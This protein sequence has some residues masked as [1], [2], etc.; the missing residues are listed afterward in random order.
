MNDILNE[1]FEAWFKSPSFGYFNSTSQ[2]YTLFSNLST[3][4]F[5]YI[6]S[7]SPLVSPHSFTRTNRVNIVIHYVSDISRMPN[8]LLR[9]KHS[10]FS[11]ISPEIRIHSIAH[12]ENFL[13]NNRIHRGM[14]SISYAASND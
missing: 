3:R 5:R 1:H 8:S 6:I 7:R 2:R 9:N 12:F 11:P 14:L 10:N 13:Q 4:L